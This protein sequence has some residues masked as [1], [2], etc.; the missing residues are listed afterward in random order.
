[1]KKFIN[2]LRTKR[3]LYVSIPFTLLILYTLFGFF[4]VPFTIQTIVP[5]FL[6][7]KAI[8]SVESAKFNPFTYELNLTKVDL[9]TQKP[10]FQ[11]EQIDTKINF[12]EI[13]TLALSVEVLRFKNPKINIEKER[14]ATY[15][16][17]VFLS[18]NS[19]PKNE[20][21]K[22]SLFNFKLNHLKIQNGI[23]SYKD[24]S[25][26]EPF[27][28]EFD[29]IDYEISGINLS[30][31]SIGKH[32]LGATSKTIQNVK[33]NGKIDINPF[34]I[35]GTI[36]VEKLKINPFWLSFLDEQ[37]IIINNGFINSKINYFLTVENGLKLGLKESNLEIFDLDI[38]ENNN[39]ILVKSLSIPSINFKSDIAKEKRSSLLLKEIK[40]SSLKYADMAEL[41][42]F[43]ASDISFDLLSNNGSKTD[44][45][46]DKIALNS[47]IFKDKN[48]TSK[49]ENFSISKIKSSGEFSDLLA[50][51][52]SFNE[53]N[54]TDLN[55][56]SADFNLNL[57]QILALNAN[58]TFKN[59]NFAL[60]IPSLS[61]DKT[62][63]NYAFKDYI[64]LSNLSIDDIKFDMDKNS[65]VLNLN[66]A[67]FAKTTILS[68]K[69]EFAGFESFAINEFEFDLLNQ[70]LNIKSLA[71]S[72]PNFSS[73]VGKN[74]L[75]SI[76]ELSV[77][78][79]FSSTKSAQKQET[80][81]GFNFSISNSSVRNATLKLKDIFDIKPIEHNIDKIDIFAKNLSSDFNSTFD[82]NASINSTPFSLKTAG[83]IAIEPLNVNLNLEL[84]SKNL[85]YFTPYLEQFLKASIKSGELDLNAKFNLDKK[86][87]LDGKISL[88]NFE[89]QDKE[90]S[91]FF[92]IKSLDIAQAKLSESSLELSKIDI[93]SPF[94]KLLVQKD[95]KFNILELIKENNSPKTTSKSDSN[96][97]ISLFDI[98]VNDASMD[99]ADFSLFIPFD[100]KITKLNSKIDEISQKKPSKITLS[101][102]VGNEGLSQIDIITLP[103]SY[104][105]KTNFSMIFK[106]V[107]LADA[108]PYSAKF[109]GYEIEDGRLN[110]KLNYTIENSKLKA[111]NEINLD[112]FS[113]GK[114]VESKEAVNLP[115][116][117]AISILKDQ[118]GQININLPISGDLND[119]EF[120]YGGIIWGAVTKLFSDI[121]LSP[122]RL[123]GNV[124][125]IDAGELSGIDFN[126]A[127]SKMLDSENKKIE[128]LTK[129]TKEKPDIK[130][131]L[132]PTYN[133]KA[134]TFAF[135][136][137]SFDE[138]VSFLMS[139]KLL[140]YK[141]AVKSLQTSFSLK[142]GDDLEKRLIEAQPFDKAKLEELAK[143]RAKNL[144]ESLLELGVNPAQIVIKS[145]KQTDS[146]QDSFVP[147]LLGVEN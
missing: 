141:N 84:L 103:F 70:N 99:F 18:Q 145:V 75:S 66:K 48:L 43:K 140:S 64:N 67:T 81:S 65:S 144:Q 40:L 114:K 50:I 142:D 69:K 132:T 88:K 5:Y 12:Q 147:V 123:I 37:K 133:E 26:F 104:K 71:L 41:G 11:A 146:K 3:G 128:N 116:S 129:I 96:F 118:N 126:V 73:S 93:N 120:S 127:S 36:D 14:N 2:F 109:I 62:G 28:I 57:A 31:N 78:K 130:I 95:K 13:F 20:S 80:K 59:G 25:L 131:T 51:N 136:K 105:D 55:I 39:T 44:T 137:R 91:K 134:D 60:E 27:D 45:K 107:A 21:N 102:V 1:M 49:L 29:D 74:G 112:K 8:L 53:A 94:I 10:L 122:F 56:T 125:G 85:S 101:G 19:E 86:M 82:I 119:P 52:S 72:S 32:T 111:S 79:A 9:T 58:S 121:V 108:T 61:L 77:L 83:K 63:L 135:K 115:I 33:Y 22:T 38:L 68:N 35:Y 100:T 7:D 24:Y 34:K 76:N 143:Q 4:G 17:D 90:K 30:K 6:K 106:D 124:L 87:A 117:L 54:A 23:L 98:S 138:A 46:I 15:N 110:L 42:E 47:L 113:L 92:A 89:I 97:D 16:F 139:S